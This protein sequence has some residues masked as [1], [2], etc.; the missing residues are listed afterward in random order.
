M[1]P[2]GLRILGDFGFNYKFNLDG[3]SWVFS[4]MP[5]SFNVILT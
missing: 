1:K 2:D 5:F 4:L 3:N